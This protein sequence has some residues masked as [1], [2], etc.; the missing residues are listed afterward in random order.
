M[1]VRFANSPDLDPM[2]PD[3][4]VIVALSFTLARRESALLGIRTRGGQQAKRKSGGYIS[5]APDG[6]L[7]VTART[8][9]NKRHDL[10][11][12]DKWIELDPERQPIIREAWDLLLAD[13]LTL[14]EIAEALHSKGYRHRTGRPFVEIKPDGKRKANISS[15]S[16]IYHNWTY[17]GW[18][19]SLKNGI[20]PKTIRGNWEP[21]IST[22]EFETAQA[23]LKRRNEHRT[24]RMK[25]EYLLAGL[26]CY[27]YSDGK[28]RRMS[29]STS[30][31]GRKGGGTPYYRIAGPGEPSFL[32]MAIDNA[33]EKLICSIQV[34]PALIPLIRAS[35]TYELQERLGHGR[36][37]Q[38]NQ[39]E[40]SLKQI[41]DE[42]GRMVRLLATGKITD[43]TWDSLWAEWQDRRQTLRRMLDAMQLEH[44]SHVDNL[45]AALQII[46][47][48]GTLYNGLQRSDKKELLRQ[49]VDRVI[50]NN[51]GTVTLELR[52][53]FD[54]L[55]TLVGDIQSIDVRLEKG[56][57]RGRKPTKNA[58]EVSYGVS[59]EQCSSLIH[60]CSAAWIRTR[61]LP[62]NSRLLCR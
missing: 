8:D 50:V 1:A 10:G 39:L 3:D 35:Y 30:N 23:I 48:I 5:L 22:E 14:P 19:V 12:W 24:L 37:V 9:S 18:V 57:K 33:V 21:M 32:C 29:A 16:N 26:V 17:A 7:N 54:Y 4:R 43:E 62:V 58:A 36:P 56:K 27:R 42:E 49:V 60:S 44:Q 28:I 55:R 34:D 25:R 13:R 61:N 59:P 51:D 53:P 20:A 46:A 41:D 52:T 6:Y 15:L 45:E 2:D 47:N 40:A 11:R 38:R 31:G